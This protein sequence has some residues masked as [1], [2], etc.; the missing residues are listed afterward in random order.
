[1]SREWLNKFFTFSDP[2]P[3][4]NFDFLCPHGHLSPVAAEKPDDHVTLVSARVWDFLHRTCGGGPVLQLLSECTPCQQARA[5][6]RRRKHNEIVTFENM[7]KHGVFSEYIP[8]VVISKAWLEKWEEFVRD[9]E[10]G[11]RWSW[12]REN[13]GVCSQCIPGY[14]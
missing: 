7:Q 4:T 14:F 9:D 10:K 13:I 3:I 6:A 11:R 5:E 8:P 2:G 12:L 1:M